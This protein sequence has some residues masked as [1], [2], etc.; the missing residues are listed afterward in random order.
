M[1]TPLNVTDLMNT[2]LP[3]IMFMLVFQMLTSVIKEFR[4]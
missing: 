1:A 2:L 3:L 4:S